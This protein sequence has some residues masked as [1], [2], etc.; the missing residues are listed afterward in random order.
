MTL[1][2]L[3]NFGQNT[4][5]SFH[6]IIFFQPTILCYYAQYC[7]FGIR[8]I[9]TPGFV[10]S[11]IYHFHIT[12]AS[13]ALWMVK[14]DKFLFVNIYKYLWI[15]NSYPSWV[16]ESLNVLLLFIL[17]QTKKQ[18][19]ANNWHP[20]EVYKQPQETLRPETGWF[21][22]LPQGTIK[23]LMSL[24]CWRQVP[25]K[26]AM[27]E[28]MWTFGTRECFIWVVMCLIRTASDGPVSHRE[29]DGLQRI[30]PSL[31]TWTAYP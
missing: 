19:T 24:H 26:I 14:S 10:Q 18:L 25:E 9:S 16:S 31:C 6:I 20:K 13:L 7:L 1:P 29:V 2:V 12:F 28:T 8:S 11:L 4:I 22:W 3:I 21:C 30:H 23:G 27:M 17:F 5:S 15:C